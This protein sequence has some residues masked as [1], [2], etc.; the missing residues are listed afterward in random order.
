MQKGKKLTSVL[1]H[2]SFSGDIGE[3]GGLEGSVFVETGV[4]ISSGSARSITDSRGT[5]S[6]EFTK[7]SLSKDIL[8][9]EEGRES[10]EG[11]ELMGHAGLG[12][13]SPWVSGSGTLSVNS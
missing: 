2:E 13:T 9:I 4:T 12:R 3:F 7:T 6:Q 11:N 8:L 10:L 5:T 1:E